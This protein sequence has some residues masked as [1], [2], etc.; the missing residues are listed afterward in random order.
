VGGF[1]LVH[2]GRRRRELLNNY[3]K[4]N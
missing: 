4:R 1:G 3:F 2:G